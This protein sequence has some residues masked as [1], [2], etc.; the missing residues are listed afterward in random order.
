MK[1]VVLYILAFTGGVF[2]AVQA[3]FNTQLGALTK[4]P[5]VAVVS[6]SI[7][8][9]IFGSCFIFFTNKGEVSAQIVYEVPWY[10]WFVGGLFSMIGISLYFYTIPKLGISKMIALGLC[11]QLL[12]SLLAGKF[13]WLN[14]PIEPLTPRKLIGVGALI[15]GIFLINSK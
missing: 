5:V 1:L 12:F 7:A 9:A 15:T 13:G 2:L 14:L 4:H 11:G 10:L 6:T 3:G 8:S